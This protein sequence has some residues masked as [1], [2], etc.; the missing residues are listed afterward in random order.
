MPKH[1]VSKK[2]DPSPILNLT[3]NIQINFLHF[4]LVT[5]LLEHKLYIGISSFDTNGTL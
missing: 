4:C 3:P 1:L 5:A 2:L